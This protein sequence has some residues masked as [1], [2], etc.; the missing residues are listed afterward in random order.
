MSVDI[1]ARCVVTA[2]LLSLVATAV[3][4]R[5]AEGWG[6]VFP[7]RLAPGTELKQ[8][9]MDAVG[10]RRLNAAYIATTVDAAESPICF[11][12]AYR[13][14]FLLLGINQQSLLGRLGLVGTAA[15][16]VVRCA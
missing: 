9:L 12:S 6:S 14:V 16:G 1:P 3:M 13:D 7:L 2:V 4:L 11:P 8:A 10:S 5:D 15:Y